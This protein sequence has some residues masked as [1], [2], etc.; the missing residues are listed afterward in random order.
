ML[1]HTLVT[2]VLS[3]YTVQLSSVEPVTPEHS[4]L[5]VTEAEPTMIQCKFPTEPSLSFSESTLL[6]PRPLHVRTN[7]VTVGYTH[8]HHLPPPTN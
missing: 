6:D 5:F 2:E 8:N 4:L 7:Y 3:F 1:K